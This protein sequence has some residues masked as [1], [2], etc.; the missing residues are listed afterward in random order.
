MSTTPAGKV[1]AN[2]TMLMR[3]LCDC[4]RA[5]NQAKVHGTPSSEEFA[6]YASALT[7]VPEDTVVSQFIQR[8]AKYWDRFYAQDEHFFIEHGSVCFSFV[9][10]G[11]LARIVSAK[12]DGHSVIK[13][14]VKECIWKCLKAMC[15]FS[16][17]HMEQNVAAWPHYDVL[18]LRQTW[19]NATR[20]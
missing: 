3:I 10:E 12:V 17:E 2:S 11:V 1:K 9:P 8:T 16:I 13:D 19:A 20:A 5:L 4:C 15:K 18:A 7:L 14:S 6:G